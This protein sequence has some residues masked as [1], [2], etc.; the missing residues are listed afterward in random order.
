MKIV[1]TGTQGVGKTTLLDILEKC[2]SYVEP[3][4][5]V[6]NFTRDMVKRGLSINEAG[7]DETQLAIMQAHKD[8]VTSSD[9][10]IMDRCM[11]DGI[12]YTTYLYR[13]GNVSEEVY[14]KC[15]DTFI[16]YIAD[17]DKIYYMVPEFPLTG[18]EFRSG[19]VQYQKD[20]ADIFEEVIN[21]YG[22]KVTKL[23]GTVGDRLV[24]V[25][26]ELRNRGFVKC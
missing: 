20:I 16:H 5:F 10:I 2:F 9:N 7:T 26:N 3:V 19:K 1:F 23:T 12:V 24:V 17:Y 22:I 4:R 13:Q 8:I 6:R 25:L 21:K 18:D 11:L 15:L 14:Q